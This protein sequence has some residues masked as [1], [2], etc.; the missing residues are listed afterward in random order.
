MKDPFR[1]TRKYDAND[2]PMMFSIGR[3][4]GRN[5]FPPDPSFEALFLDS[6]NG[7]VDMKLTQGTGAATFTRATTAYTKLSSGLWTSV[8]SGTARSCYLG[9]NTAVGSYG[10]YLAEGARTQLVTPTASIRDMTDASWVKT[11]MTAAKTATGI[12]GVANSCTTLTATAGNATA[13][14]TLT[15]AASS[16]TYSC[17]IKRRTGTGTINITQDGAAFT[18]VTSQIN[19]ST[20]TLVQL[21]ASILNATFGIRIVTNGDAIDVDFNQFEAGAFAS[22]PIDNAGARNADVLTYASAGNAAVANG[23]VYLEGQSPST[24]AL[25]ESYLDIHDGSTNNRVLFRKTT[26][27]SARLDVTSGGVGQAAEAVGA[28]VAGTLG[29]WAAVWGT[30]NAAIFFNGSKSTGDTSVTVPTSFTTILIGADQAAGQPMFGT[31]KNVRI[32]SQQLSNAT[33]Q[34]MTS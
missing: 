25:T 30:N 13:I 4:G 14:Q 10:G 23:S 3:T 27:P 5:K 8:S 17:W 12:D 19:S 11:T 29:K 21:N 7:V 26:V 31:I 18:D 33:L 24:T 20:F 6:G 9:L 22:S 34:N 16:R 32:W 1:V 28:P 15:A 2:V